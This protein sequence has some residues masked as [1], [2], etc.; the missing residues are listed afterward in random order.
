MDHTEY[1]LLK[2]S[3]DELIRQVLGYKGKFD[4][5]SKSI[6]HDILEIIANI[7]NTVFTKSDKMES[8]TK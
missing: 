1:Q 4:D 7:L 5:F 2:L 3:K 8:M 6:W